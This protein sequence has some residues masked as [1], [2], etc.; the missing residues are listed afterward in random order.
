[1]A[2]DEQGLYSVE[3]VAELLGLHVRTVRG[4]IRDGRLAATRIG[5][6]YRIARADVDAL[7]G[8]AT[9]AAPL[10]V[11]ASSV[12]H[13]DGVD[14]RLADR[15]RTALL[16]AIGGRGGGEGRLRVEVVHEPGRERL[17]VIVLGD[18]V[19]AAE[20]LRLVAAL[21]AGSS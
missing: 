18:A 6:Q 9:P 10:R 16:G 13:V 7:A 12:V 8:R 1:M 20:V 11:D 14:A 21:V 2:M 17:T 3:Q 15:L 4:Y 19:A 5:K